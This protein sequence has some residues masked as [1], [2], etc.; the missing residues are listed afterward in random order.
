MRGVLLI[1]CLAAGPLL[2]QTEYHELES[3]RPVTVEDAYV[4]ARQ[5]IELELAP[6]TI[7]QFGNGLTR[8][9]LEPAVSYGILPRTDIELIAPFIFR[10]RGETPSHGV[11]QFGIAAQY[12]FNNESPL[13]PAFAL[14]AEVAF[15]AGGAP[16]SGTLYEGRAIATK[17]LFDGLRLHVNVGFSSYHVAPPPP[18][19][20]TCT[21]NCPPPPP[22]TPDYPCGIV[23]TRPTQ[24][25]E[26]DVDANVARI[27]A[28]SAATTATTTAA[29]SNGQTNGN[30]LLLGAAVDKSFPLMSLLV[31]GDFVVE[32]YSNGLPRPADFTSD[33]G[34]RKQISPRF[35]LDAGIGRLFKGLRPA[36][37]FTVG[38]TYT[39]SIPALVPEARP[40]AH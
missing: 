17:S 2:A 25:S 33:V 36:W 26:A 38:T 13:L 21:K 3:G 40:G 31:V 18:P 22:P 29:A 8:A 23:D 27:A 19:P 34:F 30:V 11:T 24:I 7:E 35:V 32:Q 6:V 5:A 28:S 4:T 12:N 9:T 1:G 37:L 15:P 14:K 10:E 39:F 16:T 20:V